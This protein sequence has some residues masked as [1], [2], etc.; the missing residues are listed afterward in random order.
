MAAPL[1]FV[2]T[3]N[4]Y[5]RKQMIFGHKIHATSRPST[6]HLLAIVNT[7]S[8]SLDD[9]SNTTLVTLLS[10]VSSQDTTPKS[11]TDKSVINMPLVFMVPTLSNCIVQ[12]RP[13]VTCLWHSSSVESSRDFSKLDFKEIYYCRNQLKS[14]PMKRGKIFKSLIGNFSLI[15]FRSK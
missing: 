13:V 3:L 7:I 14:I 8:T 15:D 5:P 4:T 10:I 2:S 11:P 12:A 6:K 1:V 9:S